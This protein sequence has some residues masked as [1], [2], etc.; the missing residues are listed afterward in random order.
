MGA[1]Q[2]LIHK[3]NK[4]PSTI[5][6]LGPSGKATEAGLM[7]F[8]R[9]ALIQSL[10]IAIIH[11]G[12]W[13]ELIFMCYHELSSMCLAFSSGLYCTDSISIH[14]FI[15]LNFGLLIPDGQPC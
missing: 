9:F 12:L 3:D 8:A 5:S 13:P 10:S 2:D 11:A 1:K 14:T 6:L 15:Q 4:H 7:R